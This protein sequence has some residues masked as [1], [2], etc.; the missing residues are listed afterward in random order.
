V[1]GKIDIFW[2]WL[3]DVLE[4]ALWLGLATVF[5]TA[6][7]MLIYSFNDFSDNM[8]NRDIMK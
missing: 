4:I 8:N 5:S 1:I 7:F 6:I 3:G 2:V